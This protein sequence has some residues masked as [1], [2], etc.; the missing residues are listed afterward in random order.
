MPSVFVCHSLPDDVVAPLRAVADTEMWAGSGPISR[1]ELIRR[2]DT[3]DGLL[4]MLTTV[5]DE[6][7]IGRLPRLRVI[8]QMAVGLDNIDVDACR[9][10]GI[11]VGHTPDVLTETVADTAFALLASVVRRI[12]E[13]ADVVTDGRW[14]PWD[15]WALLGDDLHGMTIGIIGLGRIGQAIARRCRGFE[16]KVI[17]ASP[18]SKAFPGADHVDLDE[19][20]A[21]SDAVFVSA[22]LT[23]ETRHMIDRKA[24]AKMKPTSYLVNVAR[25]QL[26]D[27]DA[28]VHA[29]AERS[30][31]AAALDVADPEPLP[32]DHPLVGMSNCLV[33]PH[34]GSASTRARVA[35][36]NL[37]VEN[38]IAGLRGDQMPAP[39]D[40]GGQ[41][42]Q[43][44]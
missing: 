4:T 36:A 20:L 44:D 23:T 25:G 37:A 1:D 17:Y 14:G 7:L 38:V 18:G 29:L 39:A 34:I 42:Q 28:L 13:A 16:M 43:V 27:T 24:L 33:V 15:P 5:V 10:R 26:V 3:C 32:A 21:S 22:P 2:A 40:L 30:I 6:W 19:L 12:P 31:R 8:S 41:D 9:E 11:L 35:M